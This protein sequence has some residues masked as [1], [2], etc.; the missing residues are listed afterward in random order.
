MKRLP[1]HCCRH[2]GGFTLVELIMIIIILGILAAV[3]MPRFVDRLAF[4]TRGF[5]D[6]TRAA[7]QFGRKV[8]L[9]TGRN[10]CVNA[11]GSTLALTMANGRGQG[12]ACSPD[13]INPATGAAYS[14]TSPSANVSYSNALSPLIFRGDGSPSAAGSLT[15]QGDS[16]ITINIDGATGY[17]R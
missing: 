5:A 2:I 14:I 1:S 6:Q 7:I 10:V 13:V 11:S 12:A 8:A 4:D 9:A 16:N 15:V 17:V 3:A